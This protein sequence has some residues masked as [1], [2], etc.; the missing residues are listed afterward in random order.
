MLNAPLLYL[1]FFIALFIYMC[2]DDFIWNDVSAASVLENH[3]AVPLPF[4]SSFFPFTMTIVESGYYLPDH[5]LWI[6]I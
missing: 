1:R 5:T 3:R 4:D 2:H 6:Y